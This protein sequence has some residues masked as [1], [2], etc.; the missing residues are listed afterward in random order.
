MFKKAGKYKVSVSTGF[1]QQTLEAEIEVEPDIAPT[2]DFEIDFSQS[3]FENNYIITTGNAIKI[4]RNSKNSSKAT[5]ILKDKSFSSDNDI[6]GKRIWFY[7]YDT[8]NDGKFDDEEKQIINDENFEEYIF[9][10][11]KVGNILIGLEVVESFDNTIKKLLTDDDYL[12]DITTKADNAYFEVGNIAPE[13]KVEISK[14]KALDL[15]FT[16]QRK[17]SFLENG[18]QKSLRTVLIS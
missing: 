13:A 7:Y 14:A 5:V 3:D 8:N 2:A 11:E 15:A 16:K 6:I 10:T 18:T 17:M 1:E 4:I 12:T 9:A